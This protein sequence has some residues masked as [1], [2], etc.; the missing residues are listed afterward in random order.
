MTAKVNILRVALHPL[1]RWSLVYPKTC[2]ETRIMASF[3]CFIIN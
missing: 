2:N 3:R 1:S